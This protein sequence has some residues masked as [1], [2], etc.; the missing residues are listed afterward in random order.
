MTSRPDPRFS[1]QRRKALWWS[2]PVH[3]GCCSQ[4]VAHECGPSTCG[5][6]AQLN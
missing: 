6:A 2:K 5:V 3:S 1:R 4:A